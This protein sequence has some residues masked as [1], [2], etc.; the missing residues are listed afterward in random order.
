MTDTSPTQACGLEKNR[1][2]A[3]V[4][5]IF[6]VALTLLVLDIKLPE[7]VTIASVLRDAGYRTAL[8]GKWGLG[9]AGTTGQPD[10]KGFE[11]SFGF[12]DQRH[13]HRRL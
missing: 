9:M 7:D 12:L 13:A 8:V 2:E 11:Y 3:L 10:K 6:A 1:V 4:D 5:G